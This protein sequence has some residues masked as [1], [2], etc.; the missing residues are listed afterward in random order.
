MRSPSHCSIKTSI[1]ALHPSLRS[2]KTSITAFHPSLR[3]IKT[4]ITA[5]RTITWNSP[6]KTLKPNRLIICILHKMRLTYLFQ[7]RQNWLTWNA[8]RPQRALK[9]GLVFQVNV[10]NAKM[11][12]M[13]DYGDLATGKKMAVFTPL[14]TRNDVFSC[15]CARNGIK[16]GDLFPLRIRNNCFRA[17]TLRQW[18]SVY[19]TEC[20]QTGMT[21]ATR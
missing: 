16:S 19:A 14:R 6:V 4:S 17:Q 7:V 12:D 10:R 8:D 15:F 2:I 18:R 5:F 11:N 3:S 21:C 9:Q 1:T 13:I 20:H